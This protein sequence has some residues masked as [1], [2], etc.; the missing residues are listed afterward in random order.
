MGPMAAAL[1]LLQALG[2]LCVCCTVRR[3][4]SGLR[5]AALLAHA[6][7]LARVEMAMRAD[8]PGTNAETYPLPLL[9]L[10]VAGGLLLCERLQCRGSPPP[11]PTLWWLLPPP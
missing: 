4:L 2:A 6:L 1:L 8:D 10:S 11:P 7:L 9:A 5:G 3:E